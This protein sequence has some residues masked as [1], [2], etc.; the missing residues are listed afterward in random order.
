[1]VDG[2]DIDGGAGTLLGLERSHRGV[3]TPRRMME[4]PVSG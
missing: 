4:G 1:M 3:L 2:L